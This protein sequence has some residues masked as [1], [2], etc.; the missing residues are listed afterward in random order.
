MVSLQHGHGSPVTLYD[1]TDT[2]LGTVAT[3]LNIAGSFSAT[4]AGFTPNGNVASR[5]V[6]NVSASVAL[7]AGTVVAVTNWGSVTAYLTL[8]V[9]AGAA[10][11]TDFALLAGATVG[12]TVGSNT[13]INAITA[14]STTDLRMAGGAGLVSGY[15]GGGSA[16]GGGAVTNAGVFAVQ[17]AGSVAHDAV[18]TGVNPVLGGGYAS[19]AAPADVSADGDS[20]REWRLRNGAAATVVTAAGA[21]IGGDAA[22]GLDV[23]VTRLPALVASSAVIGHVVVDSATGVAQSAAISGITRLRR[24]QPPKS[25][26]RL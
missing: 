23:D 6:S 7:P 17:P 26:F 9:G 4:L 3:P 2:E 14:S 10:A 8:S 20:V 1:S 11:T 22:N 19:A 21:L 18:G 16:G 12:L 5:A 15:G 24:A 13:F 25:I